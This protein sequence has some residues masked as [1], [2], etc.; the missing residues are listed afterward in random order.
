[1]SFAVIL[2][3]LLLLAGLKYRVFLLIVISGCAQ[4]CKRAVFQKF[5]NSET[6]PNIVLLSDSI[7][8]Q[9]LVLPTNLLFKNFP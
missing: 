5:G 3:Q 1:M 8:S 2:M 4:M 9:S 6:L 7:T